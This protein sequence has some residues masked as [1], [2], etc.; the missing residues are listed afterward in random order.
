[1]PRARRGPLAILFLTVFI[2]LVGFAIVLP[3]LPLY[4]ERFGAGEM[5]LGWL[6]A[7]FSLMQFL[8]APLW[9]QLSDRIGR[10]PVILISLAGSTLSYVLFA[11]A[12]I[13]HSLAL[14]FASRTLGGIMGANIPVAQAYIADTTSAEDRAHGM[15]LIGAAFGLGFI[16]GPA[17]ASALVPLGEI[18]PGIGAAVICGV[19]LLLAIRSL[20]EALPPENRHTGA[21]TAGRLQTVVRS[22]ALPAVRGLIVMF[23][24]FT[25]AI[26]IWETTLPAFIDRRFGWLDHQVA[27]IYVYAGVLMAFVQ[28]F[29]IRRLRRR[30]SEATLIAAG[31]AIATLGFVALALG[32]EPWM[33]LAALAIFAVGVGISSPSILGL[34]SRRTAVTEQGRILGVSQSFSSLA[35]VIGPLLGYGLLGFSVTRVSDPATSPWD[36]AVPFFAAAVLALAVLSGA[37]MLHSQRRPPE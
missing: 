2:D 20:P 29:L 6:L 32:I 1:M 24:L 26:A 28:G 4:A 10:R 3:L 9:G 12:S 25:V 7:I 8:F 30:A 36:E 21:A 19:N 17:L 31:S 18:W 33:H 23:F 22:L 13:G 37:L 5:A 27:L 16:L 35:R 34:L 14:L 11:V 15:G